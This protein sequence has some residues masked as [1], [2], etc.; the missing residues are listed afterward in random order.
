LSMSLRKPDEAVKFLLA[1]I[2]AD[3]LNGEAH[4]RLGL[5]YRGLG[6]T[7]DSE[8]ELRLFQEIKKTKD[9]VKDLYRQMNKQPRVD[10]FDEAALKLKPDG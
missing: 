6:R 9:Q 5:A 1:T 2:Q 7:A 4:Y 3:P 10:R 8:K